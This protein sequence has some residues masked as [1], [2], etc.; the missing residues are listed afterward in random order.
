MRITPSIP[1]IKISLS[2]RH[3]TS[4]ISAREDI[5]ATPSRGPEIALTDAREEAILDRATPVNR[6][7]TVVLLRVPKRSGKQEII[8]LLEGDGFTV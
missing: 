6:A 5:V 8:N 2:R 3:F 7:H 1:S 4:S